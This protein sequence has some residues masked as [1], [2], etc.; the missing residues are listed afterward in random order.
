MFLSGL[1]EKSIVRRL[2]SVTSGRSYAGASG[3]I[4]SVALLQDAS[5]PFNSKEL[6]DLIKVLGIAQAQ[7]TVISYVSNPDKAELVDERT[8]ADKHL[9][10]KGVFKPVHLRNFVEQSFDVLISY[11]TDENLPLLALSA[12]SN[13]SFKVG[14]GENYFDIQDLSIQIKRD[15]E[16]VFIKELEKYLNILKIKK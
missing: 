15:Q 9:G 4:T 11:Y 7:L 8:V 16:S 13:A 6:S 1:K 12:Q 14:I 10:W 3:K 5:M 2:K